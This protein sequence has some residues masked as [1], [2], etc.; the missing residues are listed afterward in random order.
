MK[1][2]YLNY[3]KDYLMEVKIAKA[4]GTYR[5]YENHLLNIGKFFYERK[6]NHL[7][8][9]SKEDLYIYISDMKKRVSPATIN[10]R[11]GIL[12]RCFLYYDITESYIHSIPKFKET[13][14]S[15]PRIPDKTLKKIINYI[16]TL[17]L[18]QGN[19]LMYAGIIFILIN[20]GV[21]LNELYNIEKRNVDLKKNE[22][23]L[24]TTKT[25]EERTVYFRPIINLVVKKLLEEETDHKYLLHNRLRNRPVNYSDVNYLFKKLKNELEIKKLH[26]HMFRHTYATKL[27]QNGVDIKTVMDFMGHTNL[28]TTQRY[29]HGDKEHARKSY[30]TK[31]KY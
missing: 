25:G 15:F 23:L 8:E 19:N 28:S 18:D 22:I 3:F 10:K 24:T 20:T 12:K 4:E 31:Y 16:G 30:L 6:I 11:V 1:E 2:K 14:K 9:V 26:A 5:F 17:D 7:A 13:R 29:Q 21:R 27:L